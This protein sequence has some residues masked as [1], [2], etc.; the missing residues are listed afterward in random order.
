MGK[1]FTIQE[2]DDELILRLKKR[3]GVET[4]IDVVRAGLR[5]LREKLERDARV[6]RWRRAAGLAAQ[7]SREVNRELR[8]YSRIKRI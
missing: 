4:K 5:L 7:S 1:P 2:E 8:N 6:R 3:A